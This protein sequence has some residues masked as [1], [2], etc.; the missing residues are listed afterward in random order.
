MREREEGGG[1]EE[2]CFLDPESSPIV[3]GVFMVVDGRI[4][5]DKVEIFLEVV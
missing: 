4:V 5:P 3:D 1:V 2:T